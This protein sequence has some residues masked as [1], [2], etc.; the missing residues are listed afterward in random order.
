MT[1]DP[2]LRAL[3]V[4]EG[5]LGGET[6]MTQL[7][8]GLS[9]ETQVE[10]TFATVPPGNRLE[11]LL[12]RRFERIGHADMQ[13][14]R[15]RLRWSWH[16]RRLLERQLGQTDV[17]LINTPASALLSAGPMRRLPCVLSSAT[18]APATAGPA[19][20]RRCCSRSS[21][22]RSRARRGSSR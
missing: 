20:R 11:R 16:A 15:W 18:V 9:N 8:S 22:A 21:G 10:A 12:L 6:L 3:F 1:G 4:D 19:R 14:L 7:R 17:A 2:T 13:M 5:V